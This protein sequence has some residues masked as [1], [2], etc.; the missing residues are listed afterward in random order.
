M[1]WVTAVVV[2]VVVVVWRSV[3]LVNALLPCNSSRLAPA[4]AQWPPLGVYV[5]SLAE[6]RRSGLSS[7]L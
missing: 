5:Y 6:H 2:V 1:S 3:S 4:G 7:F